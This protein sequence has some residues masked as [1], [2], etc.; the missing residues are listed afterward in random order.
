MILDS[1]FL[2]SFYDKDDSNHEKAIS[3]M[4]NYVDRK[5]LLSEYVIGE[6][7]TVL[8]YKNGLEASKAFLETVQQAENFRIIFVSEDDFGKIIDIYKKQK[9]QLSFID[10][11]LVYLARTTGSELISF[12]EDLLK[13]VKR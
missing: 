11:S 1:S 13:E 9:H 12:D 7:A 8:L 10:A 4:K 6:T 5:F 2:I 3:M